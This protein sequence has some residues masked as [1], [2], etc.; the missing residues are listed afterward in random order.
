MAIYLLVFVLLAVGASTLGRRYS[1]AYLF[2][3]WP[4]LLVFVGCRDRVGPDWYGYELRYSQ[5]FTH[6]AAGDFLSG[7]SELGFWFIAYFSKESGFGFQGL[8]A[9]F[10]ALSMLGLYL[11]CR[12]EPRGATVFALL[13][14]VSV[15]QLA[16]SGIRQAVAVS[17]LMVALL[18]WKRSRRF[19]VAASLLVGIQFHTSL[20]LFLPLIFA[21]YRSI[22]SVRAVL[23]LVL[24][25]PLM[26]AAVGSRM[27]VYVERYGGGGVVAGGAFFRYFLSL[28]PVLWCLVERRRLREARP[29]LIP[30]FEAFGLITLALLP[31]GIA[32]SIFLHRANYYL[33]PVTALMLTE[34]SALG[35]GS[36]FGRFSRAVPYALYGIYMVGWFSTSYHAQ[37]GYIPYR[38]VLLPGH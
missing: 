10:A 31:V 22:T 11:F 35:T 32:S 25:V 34:V 23:S 4:S 24:A 7:F 9:S 29:D 2:V 17:F 13:F 1:K 8:I 36:L 12:G 15:V 16:M 27:D 38:S 28:L 19:L 26:A 37:V 20:L 5:V 21:P 3:A 30:L 14:P 33:L 18:A 6:I